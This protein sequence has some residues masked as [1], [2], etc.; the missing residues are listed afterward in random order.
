MGGTDMF[1]PNDRF[2]EKFGVSVSAKLEQ[3]LWTFYRNDPTMAACRQ[4]VNGILGAATIELYRGNEQIDVSPE[5]FIFLQKVYLPLVS[6]ALDYIRVLGFVPCV[7]APH[8]DGVNTVPVIP[9]AGACETRM[10][11][12]AD[13]RM[14]LCMMSRFSH[15]GQYV[16]GAVYHVV[17]M[18]A[19]DGTP[20]SMMVPLMLP[21]MRCDSVTAAAVEDQVRKARPVLITQE[22]HT[23]TFG[24]S[25][26]R[27][28]ADISMLMGTDG[29]DDAVREATDEIDSAAQSALVNQVE[30]AAAI[31][32]ATLQQQLGAARNDDG[33]QGMRGG[34]FC[35]PRNHEI[36]KPSLA[37]LRQDVN[38]HRAT[39]H[40]QISA[41]M[42]VPTSLLDPSSGTYRQEELATR[43]LNM[44]L[45]RMEAQLSEMFTMMY[46]RVYDSSDD[47]PVPEKQT[48]GKR[49]RRLGA[50]K[51]ADASTA[52]EKDPVAQTAA[53]ED[54]FAARGTKAALRVRLKYETHVSF[55]QLTQLARL[56]A[57][58]SEYTS[59]LMAKT[60][61]VYEGGVT[62]KMMRSDAEMTERA[63]LLRGTSEQPEADTG[64]D[65]AEAPK[66]PTSAVVSNRKAA[67]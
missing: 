67:Q 40:N 53:T 12:S 36:A 43:V 55:E 21:I 13:F 31:N 22:R 25:S 17:N 66:K 46:E 10:V 38:A 18:P 15:T 3:R 47:E 62:E 6:P 35:L 49:Q 50:G 32:R 45:A 54:T 20:S 23:G 61:G 63:L 29:T 7:F 64:D 26:D 65:A 24:G 59:T 5:F 30:R 19:M 44:E 58:K 16:E 41:A 52:T 4:I 42:G 14:R 60:L 57:F 51:S 11:M 39:L 37:E 48:R 1:E 56:D 33:R 2:R 9:P 27:Q 8:S 28:L 34:F